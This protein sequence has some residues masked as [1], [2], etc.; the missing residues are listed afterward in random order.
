MA[1]ELKD[2]EQRLIAL[3]KIAAGAVD[4]AK[5]AGA[6]QIEA[7][8]KTRVFT[9][10][11]KTDGSDIG[12]YSTDPTYVSIDGA[13]KKYGS[14]LKSSALQPI[15]KTGS[16]KFKNGNPHKSEYF[17]DGYSGF[18]AKVGRQNQ[19]IDL[20]LTG[21]LQDS[22]A[23]GLTQ[24][25]LQL[26]FI[27]GAAAELADHHDTRFGEIFT[28]SD[29]EQDAVIEVMSEIIIEELVQSLTR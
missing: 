17:G 11:K 22:I 5:V 24:T 1:S 12:S 15:G 25:G 16:R 19:K 2:L 20:N 3:A 23:T 7:D 8:F 27:N 13:K 6:N 21:N 29:E 10:G 28:T 18:R 4:K 9:N 14:Q 26:G